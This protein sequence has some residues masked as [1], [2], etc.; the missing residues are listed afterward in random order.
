MLYTKTAKFTKEVNYWQNSVSSIQ[1]F[2]G[3]RHIKPLSFTHS[4][5]DSYDLCKQSTVVCI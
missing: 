3:I 1:H 4:S 5:W 2:H